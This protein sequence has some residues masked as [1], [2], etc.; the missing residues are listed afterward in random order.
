MG[1]TT[2]PRES[3]GSV[4]FIRHIQG[5]GSS[6]QVPF[7]VHQSTSH[8]PM[9]PTAP[10]FPRYN[11]ANNKLNSLRKKNSKD[12][13]NEVKSS[14]SLPCLKGLQDLEVELANLGLSHQCLSIEATLSAHAVPLVYSR[15]L[16]DY[17]SI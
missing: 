15:N 10:K 13:A 3:I 16:Q 8:D 2:W 5:P 14:S 12:I 1:T 9:A 4:T 17:S 7:E 6:N 11:E